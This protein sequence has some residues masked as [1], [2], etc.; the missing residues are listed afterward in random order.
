MSLLAEFEATSP[1]LVLG[2]TLDALPSLTLELE[3][4]YALDPDRPIVF[5]WARYRDRDRLERK[6]DDDETIDEFDRLVYSGDQALYRIRRSDSDVIS[7]YRQWVAAGGELLDCLGSEGR[8]EVEMRFPDRESFA[9]YHTFLESEGVEFELHRLAEAARRA[10]EPNALTESQREA[11]VLAYERGFFDVPRETDLA[12]I[13]EMLD[14][15]TQA[16]SERLRRGQGR[17]IDEHVL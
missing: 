14:I 6:L 15:S 9:E 2:P 10:G 7:A 12:T 11:I 4:Q 16:V 8:W 5:C 3:R 17:L 1:S 13:A